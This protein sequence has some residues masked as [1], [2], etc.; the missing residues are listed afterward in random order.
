MIY[1]PNA[2]INLGLNIIE[3]RPDGYHNIETILLPIGFED[4]LE[5]IPLKDINRSYKW[6]NSGLLID[7]PPDQ[8]ICI[9]ALNILKNNG[10][11]IPSVN[12]HLHKLIP[13]GAGLGGG[14]SDGIHM[15]KILNQYFDLGITDALLKNYAILLGADCPFF[16]DNRP[17]FATGIGEILTPLSVDLSEY[18]IGLI[19]PDIH[20]STPDAYRS[21]IPKQPKI[22]IIEA[23]GQP[24]EHWKD[25]IFNDFETSVFKKYPEIKEVK[26]YLYSAGALYASMSGSGS[27]VFGIFRNPP[28]IKYKNYRTWT[29]CIK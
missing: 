18:V 16:I 22:S 7:T 13:F 14:S 15:L 26:N 10:H 17:A 12:I 25:L 23:I 29:G 1:F 20:V 19:V 11:D 21:V 9:K 8:N 3:K 5:V 24:I 28:E 6:D 2:K 4:I 27:S